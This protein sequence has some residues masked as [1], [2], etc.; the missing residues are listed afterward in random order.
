MKQNWVYKKKVSVS[1]FP[2]V[3]PS[4]VRSFD[5]GYSSVSFVSFVTKQKWVDK[6]KVSASSFHF[7]SPCFVT[8]IDQGF[9]S[10]LSCFRVFPIYPNCFICYET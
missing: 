3:S 5:Q 1:S 4:F 10:V 9:W 6:K 2:F 8:R 7:V